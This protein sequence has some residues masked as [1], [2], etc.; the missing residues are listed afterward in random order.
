MGLGSFGDQSGT[1]ASGT[2]LHANR[3][4]LFDRLDLMKVRIPDPSGL[5]VGMA[6]IVAKNR[7]FPADFTNFCHG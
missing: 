7:P 6:N 1:K 4:S 3:P 2:D 5:V